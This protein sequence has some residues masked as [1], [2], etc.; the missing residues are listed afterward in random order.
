MQIIMP[1]IVAQNMIQS[2]VLCILYITCFL[3]IVSPDTTRSVML[4]NSSIS[5]ASP[6]AC[7]LECLFSRTYNNNTVC[8]L[9]RRIEPVRL[10]W[11]RI[12]W[13]FSVWT[14]ILM[15]FENYNDKGWFNKNIVNIFSKHLLNLLPILSVFVSK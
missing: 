1:H 11:D 12:L 8:H 4:V 15:T 2:T 13:L 6:W 3:I 5:W 14:L 10:V 7:G 9:H